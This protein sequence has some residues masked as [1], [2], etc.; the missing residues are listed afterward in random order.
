MTSRKHH[1]GMAVAALGILA[2]TSAPAWATDQQAGNQQIL[3]EL[4]ALK[5]KMQEFDAMQARIR[6]LESQLEANTASAAQAKVEAEQAKREASAATAATADSQQ[7]MSKLKKGQLQ[8]GH[9]NLGFTGWV[10]ASAGWRQ[11]NELAGPSSTTLNTP[12]PVQAQYHTNEFR[13]GPPQTRFGFVTA[14]DVSDGLVLK[15]KFEFDTLS[16]SNAAATANGGGWT[17]RVRHAWMEVDS[18]KTGWHAVLGQAYSLTIPNGNQINADGSPSADLGWMLLP[19]SEVT[20]TPDDGALAG[21][22]S[23]RNIQFRVVKEIAPRAAAAI[24]LENNQVN[25]GGDKGTALGANGMPNT[26]PTPIVSNSSYSSS[27]IFNS[28]GTMPDV[29]AKVGYDPTPQYH[30]EAWGILRSYKDAPGIA[31]GLT[32]TGSVMSGGGGLATYIKVVP[33]L[34]DAQ[35]GV[36]YGSIGGQIDGLIPDVTYDNTGKPKPIMDRYLYANLV[37]HV[38]RDLDIYLQGGIEQ[39]SKAGI[40]GNSTANAYGYGNPFGSGGPTGNLACM[41]LSPSSL[42]AT[43]KQD[44]KT[45]WNGTVTAVWRIY[46]G[47]YGHLDFLPQVQYV[48]RTL[49]KDQFGYGP[50]ADNWAFDA[51]FRYWPF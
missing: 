7:V 18:A 10:Q 51:A 41:T 20:S 25:W 34:F 46:N 15:S 49:F 45:L 2:A 48:N 21:L 19:G 28:L 6:N 16:G 37:G 27:T 17:P 26:L 32:G 9:T 8:I 33:G 44:T 5:A 39:G 47:S 31:Q 22:G 40:S 29:V 3:Q 43:C 50:H 12:F 1:Y 24:S 4:Q 36:G 14:S 23:T 42:T 35:F 30:F 13:D 38:N 11:H